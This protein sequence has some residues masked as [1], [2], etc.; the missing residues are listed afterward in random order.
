[1]PGTELGNQWT[2][3]IGRKLKRR[4]KMGGVGLFKN[5]KPAVG[6]SAGSAVNPPTHFLRI[7]FIYLFS[8]CR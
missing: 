2:S 1:M 7:T 8:V 3:K 6:G 5:N 4:E